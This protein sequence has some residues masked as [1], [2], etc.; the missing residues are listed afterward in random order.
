MKKML[1]LYLST[2]LFAGAVIVP[3]SFA[4]EKSGFGVTRTQIVGFDNWAW[5]DTPLSPAAITCPGGELVVDPTGG[6][7]CSDSTTGRLHFRDGAAWTCMTS[8]D[9]RMTGVGLYTSNGNFD[10][11]SSGSVWGTWTLVP[12]A[13]CDK[14]GSY[15][16][17][18]VMTA[19]SYWD[20]TW[21]GQRQ[22]YSVNG[23]NIWIGELKIDGKGVGGDLDGLHFNGTE[24]IET[25]TPFPVPY[26][27][28]PPVLGLFN[29][30]EGEFIGTIKE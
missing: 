8:N 16:E 24:L 27:F 18:L 7:Y 22:F 19:A 2:L 20:G 13:D 23:F 14:D 29:E 3:A 25:Y 28:L 21:N 12:T 17:E 30:P 1:V 4:A 6:P 9:P 15:P 26:E 5:N 11:N 10:A